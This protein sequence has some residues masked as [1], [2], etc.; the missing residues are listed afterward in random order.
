MSRDQPSPVARRSN[1]SQP[2]GMTS[3]SRVPLSSS[4]L[5]PNRGEQLTQIHS[6][7]S[8]CPRCEPQHDVKLCCQLADLGI[9]DRRELDLHRV[10]LP[11][12]PH[13]AEDHVALVSRLSPDIALRGE[14]VG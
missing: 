10:A 11:G 2:Q 8:L 7:Y 6:N 13:T 14:L 3:P 12:I 4:R 9:L 1:L 5:P